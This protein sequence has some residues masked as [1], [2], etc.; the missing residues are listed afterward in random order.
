MLA[1]GF[2]GESRREDGALMEPSGRNQ[3]QPVA[4]RSAAETAKKGQSVAPG[5][6]WL[7][8]PSN[9]KE[10]V[11]GSSPE[12]G[13]PKAPANAGLLL[14]RFAAL[15]PACSGMEQDLEQPDERLL[16]SVVS[17]GITANGATPEPPARR[18]SHRAR[19]AAVAGPQAGV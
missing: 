4:N 7:P 1:A 19:L 6:D 3:W 10:G 16:D 11:S 17:L 5:C 12:E 15:R 8:R 14:S 18:P 13:L 9:G 2:T